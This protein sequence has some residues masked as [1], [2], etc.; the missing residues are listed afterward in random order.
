MYSKREYTSIVYIVY[1]YGWAYSPRLLATSHLYVRTSIIQ[2]YTRSVY[3]K[4]N[5][6]RNARGIAAG[7]RVAASFRSRRITFEIHRISSRTFVR[8]G[9]VV[10]SDMDFTAW[11]TVIT[12]AI[13]GIGARWCRYVLDFHG[14][15][16]PGFNEHAFM[17]GR[18]SGV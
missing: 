8:F 11:T 15:T 4:P 13:F 3:R 6:S 10:A 2:Y 9:Q 14:S 18:K 16:G 7:N 12:T 17:P 1:T 5:Y